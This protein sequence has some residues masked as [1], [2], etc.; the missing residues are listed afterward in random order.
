M[1]YGKPSWMLKIF[2]RKTVF[3]C[4][5]KTETKQ[6]SP[7][8]SRSLGIQQTGCQE[9]WQ[10]EDFMWTSPLFFMGEGVLETYAPESSLSCCT[11][12]SSTS[13]Q[14]SAVGEFAV[15]RQLITGNFVLCRHQKYSLCQWSREQRT[16]EVAK[17]PDHYTTAPLEKAVSTQTIHISNDLFVLVMPNI[18]IAQINTVL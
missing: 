16:P 12:V 11:E 14:V 2:M 1:Q 4:S 10:K 7:C 15:N 9:A 18:W 8:W 5:V 6:A 3:L 17:L 13:K